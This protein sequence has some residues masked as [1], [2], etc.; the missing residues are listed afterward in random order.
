MGQ[1]GLRVEVKVGLRGIGLVLRVK[2]LLLQWWTR[3]RGVWATSMRDLES[4]VVFFLGSVMHWS[5]RAL[6]LIGMSP[7][8]FLELGASASI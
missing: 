2:P 3:P 7:G 5:I 1:R 4:V 6:Q 8:Y